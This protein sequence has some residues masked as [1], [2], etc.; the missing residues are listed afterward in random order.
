MDLGTAFRCSVAREPAATAIVDGALRLDFAAWDG[1]IRAVAGGLQAMGLRPG[2]HFVALVSNR[3]EMATLYWACQ[4][5]G[6]IFTP[7]NWR[8]GGPEMAYVIADAEAK[9]VAF[10]ERSQAAVMEAAAALGAAMPPLVAVGAGQGGATT[11]EALCAAPRVADA[12]GVPSTDICL[13]LYT[14]GTTGRPK[15]VPRSHDAER[16]AAV[17]CIAQ[18]RYRRHDATLGVM[19]L[20]HTMGIRALLMTMML[21]GTFVCMP[22]F[23]AEA[24]MRLVAD[25]GIQTLFLVPTM[26]H[27][28]VSHPRF[29]DHDL[30]S[31]KRLGYAGMSMTSALTEKVAALFEPEVFVNYYGSSEIYSFAVCDRIVDKPG[32][33][34]RAALNQALRI[35]RADPDGKAH[36]DE[37]VGPGEA[38]E[39]AATMRSPEAFKGYWKRP[40]ADAKAIR[41]GWYF[42][43]DLGQW[44]ADGDLQIVG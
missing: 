26:F 24:A 28:I 33:A 34:G 25:E 10:E 42:T 19:P 2:D 8:A 4:M 29:A 23:D 30:S 1:R 39:I 3:W 21:N 43:G 37:L 11:F 41:D 5:L 20:F 40:D 15:G 36:P 38:G 35:V 17:S 13:M 6:L 22:T 9:A 7:F 44:D 32:C 27:D 14:S 12:A 16:T 18:L 31:A